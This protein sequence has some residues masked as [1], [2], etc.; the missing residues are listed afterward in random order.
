MSE[1]TKIS[2][3]QIGVFAALMCMY[4]IAPTHSAVNVA[5]TGL[6]S[7]YGVDANAI[8][9]MVSITNLLEIPAAFVIGLVAGRKLSYRVC[10]LLATALVFIGGLPTFLGAALPWEG[11]LVTRAILGLGLGCFMPVVLGVITL[12]FQKESVRA[13]M[14]SVASVIFNIGM[15][16]TTNVAGI[17]G[18]ISWNLAW[19]IY[20]FSLVPF[21]LCIFLLTPKNVPAVPET[22]DKG[23]K[24]K[25]KLPVSG[26]LLLVLFLGGIIMSQSLFNLG[27][28]TIGAV[29][30]NPAVI[31]TIFS[32]FSVGAIAAAL[33]FGPAYKFLNASVIPVFWIVGI[34]GYV[35]WYVAHVTG[36]VALFYVAIILAGFGTNTMT[37]G[38]PMLLSTFVAP[39]IVGAVMG[40][41]YVFQNGGGFLASPIDQLVSTVA[42]ADAIMSSVW[43]F[44]IVIGVIVLIG[45]FYVAKKAKKMSADK[46][47]EPSEA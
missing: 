6:M 39:A 25:I 22:D 24:V 29:V 4:F 34:V 18:A 40:F 23:E 13:T 16:V 37:V 30:D 3:G 47:A 45:L 41:S 35:L 43:I 12:M 46:A 21:V 10:A 28:A 2:A 1:K 42:G 15:I 27:G 14:M 9:Y 5:S 44:N 26:W 7:T 20:L 33:L 8:S 36:N 17:L 31:G 38:V 19:G 32:L 11:I